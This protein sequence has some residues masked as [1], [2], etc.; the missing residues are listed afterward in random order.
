MV[1]FLQFQWSKGLRGVIH[2]NSGDAYG[3]LA[4]VAN[5]HGDF[6]SCEPDIFNDE[7][8]AHNVAKIASYNI[9]CRYGNGHARHSDKH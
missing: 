4:C 7:T 2:V 5:V 1:G 9:G 8:L 3:H 6:A